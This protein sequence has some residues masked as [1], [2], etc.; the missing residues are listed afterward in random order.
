MGRCTDHPFHTCGCLLHSFVSLPQKTWLL[1]YSRVFFQ[2]PICV[3]LSVWEGW[4]WLMAELVWEEDAQ[5]LFPL[6]KF[7]GSGKQSPQ[8]T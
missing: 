6:P 5:Q 4:G 1:K 7:P 8:S 2:S 3:Q